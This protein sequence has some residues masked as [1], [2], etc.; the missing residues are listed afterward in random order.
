MSGISHDGVYDPATGKAKFGHFS[1][2]QAR[3]LTYQVTPPANASGQ[4]EFSG[5]SSV[6]GQAFPIAG[7]RIISGGAPEHHPA[8]TNHDK[9]IVLVELTA[10]AA[11]WKSGSSS[12]TIPLN[13]VTR[14]A[15][16]WR[17]G[18][19]YHFVPTIAAPGCWV[20]DSANLR[21][22]AAN[23]ESAAVRSC[24]A[25]VTPGTAFDITIAVQPPAGSSAYAIEE[26]V[27]AGWI[28]SNI[29]DEGTFDAAAGVIRWGVFLDG[30]ARTLRYKLTPPAGITSTAQFHGDVSFDGGQ[31]LITGSDRVLAA[32]ASVAFGLTHC[33]RQ[34]DGAVQLRLDGASGQLCVL[35]VSTD[36]Q[37]WTV[38]SEVFLPDGELTF[39]DDGAAGP[40]RFYR[41]RVR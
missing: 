15:M 28:A 5:N 8:D 30:N 25:Q 24:A 37:T 33:E 9:R 41:L 29:S 16:I 14:A 32:D 4:Y 21:P 34:P 1:D 23:T 39:V 2:A 6:D 18:E 7:D 20:P 36:L 38:V 19:V 35:E 26:R 13:Y 40:R 10:Y 31:E 17:N 3:R 27:T 11:S 12:N 22:L